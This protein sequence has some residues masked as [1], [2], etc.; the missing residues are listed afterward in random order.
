MRFTGLLIALVLVALAAGCTSQAEPAPSSPSITLHG[1]GPYYVDNR[2]DLPASGYK[3]V[4]A[5][6]S[7]TNP[8]P[9]PYLFDP[10][11]AVLRD[12]DQGSYG[13]VPTFSS[14]PG[15]FNPTN[16][17]AGDTRRGKLVFTVK[18]SNPVDTIYTLSIIS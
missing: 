2:A 6:F 16:I 7:I 10:V 1:T 3:L 12:P 14:K 5:D 8:G 9:A 18:E 17:P 4:A 15:F 13:Y 11:N